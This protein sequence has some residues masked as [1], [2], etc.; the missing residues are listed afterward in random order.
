[1]DYEPFR[2]LAEEFSCGRMARGLFIIAWALEQRRQWVR[3]AGDSYG[4]R[5]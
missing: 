2:K 1:M 5:A 3:V 4:K